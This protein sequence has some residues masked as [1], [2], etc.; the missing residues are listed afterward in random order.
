MGV[1][2]AVA[3]FERDLPIERTRSGLA[4]ARAEGERIGR[5]CSSPEAA[6]VAVSEGLAADATEEAIR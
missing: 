1:I 5:P 4:R 3:Q 2:D 6:R